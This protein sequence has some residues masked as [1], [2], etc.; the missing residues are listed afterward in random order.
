[1]KQANRQIAAPD[2]TATLSVLQALIDQPLAIYLLVDPMLGEPL[3]GTPPAEGADFELVRAAA[4][5]RDVA[6]I[7]LHA[8]VGLAPWL[9]PYLV[10]IRGLDDP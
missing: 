7:A 5:H 9:H 8:S 1:M 4:W 10:S 3:P 2:K 6:T